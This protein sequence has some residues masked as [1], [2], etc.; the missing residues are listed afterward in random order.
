[1]ATKT[2]A[3]TVETRKPEPTASPVAGVR[4]PNRTTGGELRA[5]KI[6]FEREVLRFFNDRIRIVTALVQPV[7]FLFVLGSGLGTL[8]HL[9][10]GVSLPT[11]FYPG[12]PR[13]AGLEHAMVGGSAVVWDREYGFLR[14]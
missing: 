7:L 3:P 12:D 2:M 1:M 10:A 9:G 11:L 13:L 5:I 4:V 14:E 6:V 8:V